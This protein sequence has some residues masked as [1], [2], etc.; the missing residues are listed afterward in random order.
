LE[1]LAK[2]FEGIYQRLDNT[3]SKDDLAKMASK[4]DLISEI[5]KMA[6]KDDLISEI[7]KMASKDDLISE[8]A[9]MA[10]KDDLKSEIAKMASKDDLANFATKDDLTKF[11][12]KDD[13]AAAKEETMR[14]TGVLIEA[15]R[16]DIK[17][18]IEGLMGS[19][20]KRDRDKEENDQEHA[21]LEKVALINSADISKLDQRVGRLEGRA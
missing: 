9:K 8:I 11:A 4:D 2:Q 14:H 21:R 17:I 3:A 13:L 5:A 6:S 16:S 7:A 19:N 1:F 15:V 18:V 10:S 20:E 12:T